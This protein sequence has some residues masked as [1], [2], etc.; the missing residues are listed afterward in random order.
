MFLAFFLELSSYPSICISPSLLR[1]LLPLLRPLLSTRDLLTTLFFLLFP[2]FVFSAR[3]IFTSYQKQLFHQSGSNLNTIYPFLFLTSFLLY[4]C[5][6]P[7][8]IKNYI[9]CCSFYMFVSVSFFLT[10]NL[11]AHL[12]LLICS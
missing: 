10:Y 3:S 4:S 8:E 9:A 2:L 11:V 6:R 12:Y 7:P 5:S 1:T